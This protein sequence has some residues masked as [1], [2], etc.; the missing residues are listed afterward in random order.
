[1][2]E[3]RW[4]HIVCGAA[5]L[6]AS[7]VSYRLTPWWLLLPLVAAALTYFRRRSLTR[8]LSMALLPAAFWCYASAAD[9]ASALSPFVTSQNHT[10]SSLHSM[11][12]FVLVG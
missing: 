8:S 5:T 9:N 6:G 4:L 10:T 3:V 11:K 2:A 12:A 7:V 1:M